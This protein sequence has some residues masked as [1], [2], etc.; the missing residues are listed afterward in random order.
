MVRLV[1]QVEEGLAVGAAEGEEFLWGGGVL[2]RWGRGKGRGKVVGEGRGMGKRE[3][4]GDGDGDGG[5]SVQSR[6][7]RKSRP[8]RRADSGLGSWGRSWRRGPTSLM[9]DGWGFGRAVDR[10]WGG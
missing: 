8:Y 10:V 6:F 3:G 4:D 9:V 5:K 2:V 1:D 7:G